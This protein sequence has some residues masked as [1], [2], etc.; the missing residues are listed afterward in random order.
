MDVKVN[1]YE[2]SD[3]SRQP[4]TFLNDDDF[5]SFCRDSNI[6]LSKR[7]MNFLNENNCIYS[8]CKKGKNELIM[9]SNYKNLRKLVNKS[10]KTITQ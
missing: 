4:I 7:N 6:N 10:N 8:T 2:W 5:I 3:I 9:S 1:F